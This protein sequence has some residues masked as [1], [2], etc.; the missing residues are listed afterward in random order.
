MTKGAFRA[1]YQ[2]PLMKKV[3]LSFLLILLPCLAACA[4]QGGKVSASLFAMDTYLQLDIY[5]S[6]TD[7]DAAEAEIQ[8]LDRLF[9]STAPESDIS[10]INNAGTAVIDD[11]TLGLL[12]RSLE[13]CE[14][15]DGYLDI[16]VYPIVERWGF[17]SKNYSVPERG[18]LESLLKNVD[19]KRVSL[20]SAEILP[21]GF[22]LDLGAVAKG[23]TADKLKELLKSR[24]V[25][26][27]VLNLGG[28]VLA[29]GKKPNGEDWRVGITDPADTEKYMGVIGCS[30]KTVVTSGDYER[31]FE[32]DGKRYCHI[33]DP[34][35]GYPA[36]NGITSVTVVSDDGTK[37]D[38]LST[39]LFVMGADKARE[40]IAADGSFDC[41]ILTA[42][43]KAYITEGLTDSFTLSNTEYE[44]AVIRG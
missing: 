21:E 17:I 13:L 18:E 8:R 20:N 25:G 16:T 15:T 9:S 3:F 6:Q 28:S 29:Y 39:A 36:D 14:L 31:Y 27:A 4:P 33:I 42:D 43:K 26:S 2:Y 23:Y 44:T 37:N 30:D 40:F 5:G 10:R 12:S 7:L 32:R 34:K 22:K 24:G 1:L 19:Y 35:T 41:V 11:D 38:A